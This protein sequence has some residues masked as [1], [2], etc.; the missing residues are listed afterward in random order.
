VSMHSK[1]ELPE[2]SSTSRKCHRC[3][4][5]KLGI[6]A[7]GVLL[8]AIAFLCFHSTPPDGKVVWLRPDELARIENGGPLARIR[9]K[10]MQWTAPLWKS[11]WSSQPQI[12]IDSSLLTFS[13]AETDQTGLGAPVAT[14]RDGMRAWI[15]SSAELSAFRQRLNSIPDASLLNRPRAQTAAGASA[16]TFVGSTARLAGKNVPIGLTLD[17]APKVRSGS[18]ELLLGVTSTEM[19]VSP[20]ANATQVLSTN[21]A[22]A[23]RVLLPNSGGL[24]VA[25]C[26]ARHSY[27]TNYWLILSPTAVDARGN[28]IKL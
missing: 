25:S 21:V 13:A 15:L 20:S 17:L 23:C 1:R 8:L 3:T 26:N 9:D 2:R 16:Q 27:G 22:L 4:A 10:L 11:Y 28:P 5:L 14:N 24:V 19:I 18:L 6:I 12:L 7:S